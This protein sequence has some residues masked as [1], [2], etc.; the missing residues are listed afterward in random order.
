MKGCTLRMALRKVKGNS[1][2]YQMRQMRIRKKLQGNILVCV[3]NDALNLLFCHVSFLYFDRKLV[4]NMFQV[5]QFG[6][7]GH[8]Y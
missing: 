1:E 6:V 7:I 8:F 3:Y 2:I 5:A 4:L